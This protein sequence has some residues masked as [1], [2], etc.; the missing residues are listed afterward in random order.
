MEM[1]T[2]GGGEAMQYVLFHLGQEKYAL[3][4][5]QVQSIEVLPT[6]RPIPKPPAH[7]VG[8]A[9]LRGVITTV[10]NTA[11][12]MNSA[13]SEHSDA[14]RILVTDRG[15]YIVDAAQDVVEIEDS[16]L[17]PWDGNQRVKG[18]W[19]SGGDLI[20]VLES[21]EDENTSEVVG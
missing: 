2:N 3:P 14:A 6:V 5:H 4:I 9:N 8:V 11:S 19:S 21:I 20:L 1:E 15:A 7:V 10:L 12:I 17:E 13:P 18:V 16:E